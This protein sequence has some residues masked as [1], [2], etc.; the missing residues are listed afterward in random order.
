MSYIVFVQPTVMA[1]AGMPFG[2]VLLAT[3][4]ASAVACFVMGFVARYPFALAPGMGVNF[5]FAITV[6][7]TMGFSWQAGLAIVFIAGLIFL[8]L[9]LVG[10]REK[11]MA[12]LP[13]CLANSIG[14]AIGM[15]IAFIG[16]QWSGIV[17]LNP[18]TMV[19]LGPLTHGPPLIALAGLTVM[20]ALMARGFGPAILIGILTTSGLGIV[21]GVIPV[22]SESI[23]V[24]TEAALALDF[25]ELANRWQDALLA[26]L[27][28]FF[29]DL[30]DTVGSL[31]GLSR[32]AGF[33]DKENKLP[34]AGRAFFADALG[35]CVGALLGTSTITSYIESS[36]GIAAGARTGLAPVIVGLCFLAALFLAP[37]VHVVGTNV[38]P[39]YYETLGIEGA[40][41]NMYPAVA[42]ALIVAG[43][44]MLKPLRHVQWDDVTESLPAFLTVAFMVFGFGITEGVAMGC[45]SFAAIKAL[46]GRARAVHPAMFIIALA[47]CARYAFLV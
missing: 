33:L 9:S 17:V 4:V 23:G 44:L 25:G 22:P 11:V 46:S 16:F 19:S 24:S 38:G 8:A 39:G 7:G 27:L 34:R 1:I 3:C 40:F 36:T 32:Q 42:P 13:D 43:M 21:S 10:F 29:L 31:V 5:L 15:F 47:L 35:T 30:F 28:F 18:A 12:I 26:I 41:V 2:A 6:C 45:I 14:P 20:T 37:I